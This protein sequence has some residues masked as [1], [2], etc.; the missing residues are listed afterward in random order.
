MSWPAA[1]LSWF[2]SKFLSALVVTVTSHTVS[3]GT[4][5]GLLNIPSITFGPRSI[6]AWEPS[7]GSLAGKSVE[8]CGAVLAVELLGSVNDL[9][10]WL[11]CFSYRDATSHDVR[12]DCITVSTTCAQQNIV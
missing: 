11:L 6:G 10:A 4:Y 7:V 2:S 9:Y 1:S 3:T 5:S 8:V 12:E